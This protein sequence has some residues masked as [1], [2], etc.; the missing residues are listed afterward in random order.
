MG[1]LRVKHL[2]YT[3]VT[4]LQLAAFSGTA[5]RCPSGLRE[6]TPL[7]EPVLGV[8]KSQR[9]EGQRHQDVIFDE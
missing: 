6:Q 2:T 8:T 5:G 4:V 7:H 9:V 1:G 3:T